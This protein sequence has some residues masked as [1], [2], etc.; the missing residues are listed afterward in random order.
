MTV[1]PFRASCVTLL[2][3]CAVH[4]ETVDYESLESTATAQQSAFKDT[5]VR[6]VL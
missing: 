3:V 5:N 1:S 2:G 4:T 6:A